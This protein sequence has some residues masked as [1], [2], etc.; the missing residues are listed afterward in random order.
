MKYLLDT[1]VI[2]EIIK[3]RPSVKVTKWIKKEDEA[4]FFISVLT[5][6]E[7]HKGIEK[8]TE[9]QRKEKLHNWVE[10]DLKERFLNKII[11]I[12]MQVAIIWG[13]IQG[14]TE[15]IGKPMPAIDSLIAAT[16]IT[17]HLTVVTRNTSDMKE[18]GVVLFNPW[19]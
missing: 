11:G 14:M 7:L 10:N 4:N 5:I 17:H 16:G 8:L 9:S 6:G 3:Q 19:E 1:C 18:S 13:K 15:R 12:D 2:S